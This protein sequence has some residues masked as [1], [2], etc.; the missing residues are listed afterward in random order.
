MIQPKSFDFIAPMNSYHSL[1]FKCC[2]ACKVWLLVWLLFLA[3]QSHSQ[4][5]TFDFDSGTPA[6]VAGNSAPLDQVV[7]GVTAHIASKVGGF[8]VQNGTTAHYSVST[9]T[10]NFLYPIAGGG[11]FSTLDISF[12]ELVTNV[13]FDFATI[14]NLAVIDLETPVQLAAFNCSPTI[15]TTVGSTNVAGVYGGPNGT[16]TLAVGKL[17]YSA[18]VPFNLVHI[19]VPIIVPAPATG[20]AYQ[21]LLDNLSVK[22]AGG[23]NCVITVNLPTNGVGMVTGAGAYSSGLTATLV[24]SPAVL[25]C[26]FNSWQENGVVVSSNSVFTLTAIT[27]RTLTAVFNTAVTYKISITQ[28][29]I[30]GG[31][32]SPTGILNVSANSNLTFTAKAG[33]GYGFVNWTKGTNVASATNIFSLTPTFSYTASESPTFIAHYLPGYSI[34]ATAAPTNGG[35]ILGGGVFPAGTNITL[36]ATSSTNFVFANWQEN[37]LIVSTVTNYSFTTTATNRNLV[38]NFTPK[39]TVSTAASPAAGGTSVGGGLYLSNSVVTVV[40]KTNANYAFVNWKIGT[41]VVSA[42][43]IYSFN[44]ISNQLLVANFT[45]LFAVSATMSPTVAGSVLGTGSYPSNNLVTLIAKPNAGY[46]FTNWTA[47]K[48][49]LSTSTNYTFTLKTN[50]AVVAN[51]VSNPVVKLAIFNQV[52]PASPNLSIALDSLDSQ[53]VLRWSVASSGFTL[54]QSPDCSWPISKW[55]TVTNP[56]TINGSWC[57]VRFAAQ[58]ARGFFILVHP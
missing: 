45:R 44:V 35:G 29:P 10:N 3:F 27:N 51:F 49:V 39:F 24:A 26:T 43:Q 30:L 14:Q 12:S 18:K 55:T 8:S 19:S 52:I 20:Q 11:A 38:A 21:F 41:N 32:C 40:A 17:N 54:L 50:V 57:E 36:V 1:T 48:V 47:N 34:V 4:T 31:V 28:T 7:G 56:T 33:A 2:S 23:S 16:D 15:T 42:A 58:N 9:F 37:G 5:V 53:M 22:R 6:L 25:G 46:A 13:A